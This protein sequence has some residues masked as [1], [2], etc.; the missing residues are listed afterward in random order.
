MNEL[1]GISRLF[2]GDPEF[3]LGGGGN[4]SWKDATTLY[5]KASGAALGTIDESGFVALDL[6]AVRAVLQRDFPL[7]S[8]ARE[9]QALSALL[10]AR[11]P[12]QTMRPSVETILHA[13]FPYVYIVHTHP[14]LVNGLLCSVDGPGR[15]AELFGDRAL[16]IPYTTPGYVLS[17]TLKDAFDRFAAAGRSV[18]QIV[19]LQNHGIFV[20]AETTAEIEKI[21]DSVFSTI[22][23]A[24]GAAGGKAPDF[25]AVGAGA[26]ADATG[27]EPEGRALAEAIL[28]QAPGSSLRFV[29]NAATGVF[30]ASPEA[31][32]PLAGAFTPDHIVYS[33]AKPLSLSHEANR[34]AGDA[35]ATRLG[36]AWKAF[37]KSEGFAPRIVAAEGLGIYAVG[38]SAK[39]AD[40]ALAL[41]LDAVKIAQYSSAFGG[42]R[43]MALSDVEFIKKWEVEQYRS[44][45]A[46]Q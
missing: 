42:Y 19:L 30:L 14:A 34:H 27:D 41:F 2:G 11:L 35:P 25:S 39:M 26:A 12:G 8:A 29:S 15:A 10:A 6:A 37:V 46:S 3:V 24:F 7:D 23:A 5:I 21:Y 1:I 33:G 45:I 13:L 44:S 31:F 16:W 28:R 17:R 18:P 4:T 36:P 43:H 20:A 38:A 9:A 32:V 40:L 22:R